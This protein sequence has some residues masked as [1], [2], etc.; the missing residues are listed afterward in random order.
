[1]SP[2]ARRQLLALLATVPAAG[3]GIGQP[4]NA[5][6]WTSLFNDLESA[7]LIGRTVLENHPDLGS[8]ETIAAGLRQRHD[9][10][11]DLLDDTA[12]RPAPEALAPAMARAITADFAAHRTLTVAGWVLSRS[13]AE[14][15]A[16]VHLA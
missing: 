5:A 13:E 8:A 16:L 9:V 10:F 15:C 12:D 14:L 11:R 2:V 4:A 7:R 3:F 6:A 1:M